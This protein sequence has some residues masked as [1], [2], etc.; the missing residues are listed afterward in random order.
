M[1]YFLYGKYYLK[2]YG[3]LLSL[4][5]CI[6]VFVYCFK[7]FTQITTLV[8]NISLISNYIYFLKYN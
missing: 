1:F 4:C 6:S 7:F 3:A 2:D 5:A 8:M